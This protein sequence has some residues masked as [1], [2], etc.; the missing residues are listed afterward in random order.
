MCLACIEKGPPH[1]TKRTY[2]EFVDN[3]FAVESCFALSSHQSSTGRRFPPALHA[4]HGAALVGNLLLE[5]RNKIVTSEAEDRKADMETHRGQRGW[6]QGRGVNQQFGHFGV[7]RLASLRHSH[8]A[9]SIPGGAMDLYLGDGHEVAHD[10]LV[11]RLHCY[12]QRSI[13]E[14]QG[15]G[16]RAKAFK[17]TPQDALHAPYWEHHSRRPVR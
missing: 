15:R 16:V 1:S 12:M 6:A 17:H 8:R 14:L 4:G 11:S 10:V 9:E 2:I 13:S 7:L 3:F 5:M